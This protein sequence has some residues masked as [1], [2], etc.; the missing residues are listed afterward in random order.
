[1]RPV[2][3]IVDHSSR[4]VEPQ[5]KLTTRFM[6]VS[7]IVT[8]S[9]FWAGKDNATLVMGS[10]VKKAIGEALYRAGLTEDRLRE[11]IEDGSIHIDTEGEVSAR[12]TDS[13]FW[14]WAT[15][16]SANPAA[17]PYGC[18]SDAAKSSTS[19]ARPA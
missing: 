11:M 3:R 18:P 12:S 2:A 16:P 7:Q 13:S 15:T 17:S 14:P 4:L 1:V 19:S 10:Q 6:D 5:N 9:D 8:E